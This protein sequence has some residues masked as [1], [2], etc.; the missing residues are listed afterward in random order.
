[1]GLYSPG[2][3]MNHSLSGQNSYHRSPS[4]AFK[5]KLGHDV[6]LVAVEMKVPIGKNI[7]E[8][9]VRPAKLIPAS[10]VMV[11]Y[12]PWLFSIRRLQRYP[13]EMKDW[14]MMRQQVGKGLRI[15]LM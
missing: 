6:K 10:R 4:N 7:A 13:M 9:I 11:C 15:V 8:H 2:Q 3:K 14:W 12:A 1:M 5:L